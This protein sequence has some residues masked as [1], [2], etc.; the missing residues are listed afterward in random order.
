MDHGL[1]LKLSRARA[2]VF[3]RAG[4]VPSRRAVPTNR[5][6]RSL[7]EHF[8]EHRGENGFAARRSYP[9]PAPRDDQTSRSIHFLAG[10]ENGPVY[11][12]TLRRSSDGSSV[13]DVWKCREIR[14]RIQ[15]RDPLDRARLEVGS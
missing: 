2:R 14:A 3:P 8:A 9:T 15:R 5:L 7:A 6:A 12:N 10:H 11:R 1:Q 13:L 4:R